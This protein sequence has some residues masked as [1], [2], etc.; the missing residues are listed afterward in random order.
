MKKLLFPLL[1]SGLFLASNQG[2][3]Q[4]HSKPS[5]GKKT[6]NLSPRN[7]QATV[8]ETTFEGNRKVDCKALSLSGDTLLIKY[9]W[10]GNK[11]IHPITIGTKL[12]IQADYS[13]ME[14]VWYLKKIKINS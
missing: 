13:D 4:T 10:R 2:Y 6:A 12:S 5:K 1:L 3:S 9:G 7:I 11:H 14:R 8:L